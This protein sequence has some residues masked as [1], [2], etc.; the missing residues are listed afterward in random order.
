MW[1][2]TVCLGAVMASG[3]Y[4]QLQNDSSPDK[5]AAEPSALGD[6]TRGQ[7]LFEGKGGCTSCHRVGDTGSVLGPNLS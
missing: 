6:P 4:A 2:L 1:A 3:M 5:S 7:N